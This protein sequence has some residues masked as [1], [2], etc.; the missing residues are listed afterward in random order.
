MRALADRL[1]KDEERLERKTLRRRVMRRGE[2]RGKVVSAL[3]RFESGPVKCGSGSGW[4]LAAAEERKEQGEKVRRAREYKRFFVQDQKV[5]QEQDEQEVDQVEQVQ[6]DE[7][8]V[9]SRD[10]RK[11]TYLLLPLAPSLSHLLSLGTPITNPHHQHHSGLDVDVDPECSSYFHPYAPPSLLDNLLTN[12]TTHAHAHLLPLLQG[13]SHLVTL[14]TEEPEWYKTDQTVDVELVLDDR[15]EPESMRLRFDGWNEVG[16]RGL[17]GK[18]LGG[19]VEAEGEWFHVYEVVDS[20]PVRRGR[21]LDREEE[22]G[23]ESIRMSLSSSLFSSTSSLSGLSGPG[24]SATPSSYAPTVVSDHDESEQSPT[25]PELTLEEQTA[26]RMPVLSEMGDV[27]YPAGF[28]A[29][30]VGEDDDQ[31]DLVLASSSS[32]GSWSDDEEMDLG[33]VE[34]R[35]WAD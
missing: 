34:G 21:V 12:T 11:T 25:T 5:V 33:W 10:P 28:E 20:A 14:S 13:L 27:S 29:A 7:A 22:E 35:I 4:V 32:I 30:A 24:S 1:R 18:V 19:K 31:G 16:V 6:V 26:W 23:E 17:V 15:G 2:K 9:Q 3:K 8:I